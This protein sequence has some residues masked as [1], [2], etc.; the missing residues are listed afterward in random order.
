MILR[1]IFN[2]F[3]YIFAVIGFVLVSGYFAIRFG[4]TNVSGEVD[5]SSSFFQDN[6]EKIRSE[7]E[8]QN[9]PHVL[10][11]S[12]MNIGQEIERLQKIKNIRERNNC[13]I[14]EIGQYFPV[15]A[16]KIIEAKRKT[17]SDPIVSKMIVAVDLRTAEGQPLKNNLSGCESSQGS[18]DEDVDVFEQS[19]AS[20]GQ[21]ADIFSWVNTPEWQALKQAAVKDKTLIDKAANVSGVE[22]RLIVSSMIVEQ[23][24]LFNSERDVFKKFFEPLKIL[25]SSNKIS[26]GIMGIKEP[27]AEAVE[28]NLKDATS[29]YYLGKEKENL[30]DFNSGNISS[31]RYSRLASDKDHYYSYLYG[32]LYLKQLMT[33]WESAGYDIQYR[34]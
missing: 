12:T 11:D 6:A 30:L 19:L 29:P 34:P 22:S 10:G 24:R 15:N 2:I 18:G 7:A 1:R 16:K 32:G 26:L 28:K 33:E 8:L 25:C 31:E 20:L 3:V 21:G 27:T 23:L 13:G 17:N 5:A 9:K 4:I 14:R